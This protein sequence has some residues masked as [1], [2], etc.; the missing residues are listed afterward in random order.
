MTIY[1]FVLTDLINKGPIFFRKL[2][3]N[4]KEIIALRCL[5]AMFGHDN[6]ITNDVETA[7]HSRVEFNPSQ[8]CEDVLRCILHKVTYISWAFDLASFFFFFFF[9]SLCS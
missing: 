1:N 7:A 6:G 2:G 5:E 8:S 4:V 9:V 3:E